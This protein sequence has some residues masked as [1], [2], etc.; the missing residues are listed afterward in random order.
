[1]KKVIENV[2]I[3]ETYRK[4]MF[5]TQTVVQTDS[6]T[7]IMVKRRYLPNKGTAKDVGGMIS[8]NNRKNTVKE[9]SIEM[10]KVTCQR[11][12]KLH[13]PQRVKDLLSLTLLPS[14]MRIE[15]A[16]YL[17]KNRLYYNKSIS[18]NNSNNQQLQ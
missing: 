14:S 10:H 16:L 6:D 18:N 12:C 17:A 3:V 4:W 11:K 15:L 2:S 5:R 13:F 1:M 8:A 7:K 9:T